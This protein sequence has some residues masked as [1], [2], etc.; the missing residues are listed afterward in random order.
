MHSTS[1]QQSA[2]RWLVLSGVLTWFAVGWM[3][4]LNLHAAGA[5]TLTVAASCMLLF[6]GSF[7][8]VT[9]G[10]PS[11]L[12]R[13]RYL[14]WVLSLQPIAALVLQFV[15]P[16][17]EVLI[18]IIIWCGQMAFMT[19]PRYLLSAAAVL[20][21][22]SVFI[23]V[24]LFNNNV[25]WLQPTM[26]FAFC[27]FATMMARNTAIAEAANEALTQRN[28][29]LLATR[30]LLTVS[31]SENERLR[32]ARDLHDTLGHH[33]TA[34]SLQLEI[35][36]HVQGDAQ[37]DALKQAKHLAKLLLAE[38]RETVGNL[39]QDLSLNLQELLAPVLHNVPRLEVTLTIQDG[40]E[41][42][43]TREAETLLRA[44]QELISNSVRHAQA[45][46]LSLHLRREENAMIFTAEDDG[47]VQWPLPF[48]NGLRGMQERM[49]ALDGDVHFTRSKKRALRVELRWP[50]Q[51]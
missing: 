29:E 47:Q 46:S 42:T 21:G 28:A 30:N 38:V 3:V 11:P 39:R 9:T 4:L 20:I 48:G 49:A 45:R 13:G 23:R 17:S 41:L 1:E 36:G 19:T 6:L 14:W 31:A 24:V 27:V 15:F 8:R 5:V 40:V 2:T 34:L 51:N 35:A 12:P 50:T 7:L 16:S 10:F 32:I 37:Q 33:L 22:V 44:T 26:Y 25:H 43:R 18:L